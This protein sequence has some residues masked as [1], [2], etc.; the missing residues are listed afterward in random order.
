LKELQVIKVGVCQSPFHHPI[1]FCRL[2]TANE[3]CA[4]AAAAS[5][6]NDS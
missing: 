4:A 3:G 6:N 2:K 5:L 1:E